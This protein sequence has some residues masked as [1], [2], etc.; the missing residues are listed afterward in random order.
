[1]K[2]K[3]K[4]QLDKEAEKLEVIGGEDT[5]A[6]KTAIAA[7]I[8]E[9]EAVAKETEAKEK[10]ALEK[11]RRWGVA[12]Y[13]RLLAELLYKRMLSEDIPAGWRWDVS[14]TEKGVVLSLWFGDRLFRSGFTPT[15]EKDYDLNAVNMYVERASNT[16]ERIQSESNSPG[17]DN[18]WK[19]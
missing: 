7:D 3:T 15:G 1:M 18:V 17:G 6:A 2:K 11:K 12:T 14:P 16:I 19:T 5:K 10:K 9:K 13:T 4:Q 8:K